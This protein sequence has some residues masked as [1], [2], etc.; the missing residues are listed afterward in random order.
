MGYNSISNSILQ[1]LFY[2]NFKRLQLVTHG[3]FWHP[4]AETISCFYSF[5][6]LVK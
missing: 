6:S 4:L 2:Y 3:S 5:T 1:H